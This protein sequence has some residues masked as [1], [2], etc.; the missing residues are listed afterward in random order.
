MGKEYGKLSEPESY[1]SYMLYEVSPKYF[2]GE[3]AIAKHF[4]TLRIPAWDKDIIALSY[5]MENSTLSFSQFLPHYKRGSTEEMILQAYLISK[6]GGILR[7][8]SVYGVPPK[9]FSKGKCIYHFVR[10]KI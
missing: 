4:T 10:I 3:L 1:L 2:A 9:I 6:N 8:I 5:S 7:E